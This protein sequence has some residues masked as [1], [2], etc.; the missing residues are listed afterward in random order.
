VFVPEGGDMSGRR[1][2]L[3][4]ETLLFGVVGGEGVRDQ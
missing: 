1:V 3:F 4:A 2:A